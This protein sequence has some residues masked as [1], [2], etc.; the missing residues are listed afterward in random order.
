MGYASKAGRARVSSRNPQAQAVCDRCGIWHNHVNLQW[1]FDWA[2]ASLINK[3]ILVCERC[4]DVPQEQLRA[5]VLPQDP[6]Q[7]NNPRTEWFI[8]DETNFR[9]TSIAPAADPFWTNSS[10]SNTPWVSNSGIISNWTGSANWSNFLSQNTGVPQNQGDQRITQNNDYRVTQ[11][12]GEPPGGRNQLPG[13]DWNA[14]AVIYNGTEIGLPYDTSEVP[15]TGPLSPPYNYVV[16]W[17]NV[18]NF[19]ILNGSFWTTNAGAFVNW[20]TTTL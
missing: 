6:V 11:Q 20:T 7:I 14:P 10:G 13:T 12:T 2:G 17:N 18:W 5:I 4:L 9:Q 8:Q 19:G 15:F 3:R 1:Q 16:Q